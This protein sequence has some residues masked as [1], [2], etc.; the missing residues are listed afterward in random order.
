MLNLEITL[1]RTEILTILSLIYDHDHGI[2]FHLFRHSLISFIR[3]FI[4]LFILILYIICMPYTCSIILL[5]YYSTSILTIIIKMALSPESDTSPL[6]YLYET[7]LIYFIFLKFYFIFKLYI[8]VLVLPNIKMNPP[9]VYMCSP[10]WTLL[11]PPFPYHPSGS[12]IRKNTGKKDTK[13]LMMATSWFQVS[14]NLLVFPV[15]FLWWAY[16]TLI[17]E[18]VWSL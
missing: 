5:P 14:G 17:I 15:M 3:V 1:E 16:I 2:S 12:W 7:I 4:A 8:I 13:V 18:T 6:M 11:P 10:S 9:Q